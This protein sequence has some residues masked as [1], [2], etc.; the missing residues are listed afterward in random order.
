VTQPAESENGALAIVDGANVA[1]ASE[2]AKPRLANIRLVME[3][4]RDEGLQPIVVVDASLRHDIDDSKGYERMVEQGLIKQAP[5]GTDADY[6]I[7]SFAREL[8]ASIVTNDRFRDRIHAFADV[9]ERIIRFM[10]A[11]NA[12]VFERRSSRRD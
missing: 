12:V 2:G 3:K 8:G 5:A 7:L 1:H 11:E 9:R 4:L 6:F 10:I